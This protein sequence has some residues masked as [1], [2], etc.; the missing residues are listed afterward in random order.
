LLDRKSPTP[1]DNPS[2]TKFAA[3]KIRIVE[4]AKF[5]PA[6]PATTL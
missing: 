6:T 5:A 2:A 4:L 1:I 3:P